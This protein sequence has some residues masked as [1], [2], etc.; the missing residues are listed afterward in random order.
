MQIGYGNFV[1][2]IG[3][4]NVYLNSYLFCFFF[5][6]ALASVDQAEVTSN[7]LSGRA[8]ENT[9]K[10]MALVEK[11]KVSKEDNVEMEKLVNGVLSFS[12]TSE[13]DSILHVAIKNDHDEVVKALIRRGFPLNILDSEKR[14]PLQ[15]AIIKGDKPL[16][17]D[18]LQHKAWIVKGDATLTN[19]EDVK[20]VVADEVEKMTIARI[21]A[22]LNSGKAQQMSNTRMWPKKE[23][24]MLKALSKNSEEEVLKLLDVPFDFNSRIR[25][26]RALLHI[27][28]ARGYEK[29]VRRLL[30]KKVDVD[31][32][33]QS[34]ITPLH[35]AAVSSN[36]SEEIVTAL[37]RAGADVNAKD[38]RGMSSL[39]KAAMNKVDTT[40]IMTKLLESGCDVNLRDSA[41]LTPMHRASRTGS[42]ENMKF[43][44][45]KGADVVAKDKKGWTPLHCA[46]SCGHE[47][48]CKE[49]VIRGASVSRDIIELAKNSKNS[50]NLL[51]LF[52][53][54]KENLR[55]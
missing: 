17:E 39:H 42:V 27:A 44:L 12:Q 21:S 55:V 24:G 28:V 25:R 19:T 14:T 7:S 41:E 52:D 16:V 34:K 23:E 2:E 18:L 50:D 46:V 20:K 45:A 31:I 35:L 37:L 53:D 32:K 43:L 1:K 54:K 38:K 47:D 33:D 48:I 5:V 11:N 51:K 30:D 22:M 10:L 9:R 3:M 29:V 40:V 26:G 8:R 15:R 36:P 6:S 4:R 49:L 13:K